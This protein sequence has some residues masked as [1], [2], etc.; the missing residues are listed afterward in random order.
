M[1]AFRRLLSVLLLA[2]MLPSLT[3]AQTDDRAAFAYQRWYAL[4]LE[5]VRHTPTYTPPVASRAFAYVSIAAY[6]AVASGN[7]DLRTLA[8]QLHGLEPLPAR[9]PAAIYDEAIV[10]QAAM[11]DSASFFFSNTGP[12]GQR[13]MT[14]MKADLTERTSAGVDPETGAR[15][16]AFGKAIADHIIAWSMDDGGATI[17]NMG[18]PLDY[19]A[20]TKPFEWVP[21]SAIRQQ[22]MPLLPEWGTNRPFAMPQD[23]CPLPP[24][25]AYSEEVG[26]QFRI[27]AQE[28]HDVPGQLT[29][30]QKLI[31]RFWSDDPMLSP[32]PPGHWVTI[33]LDQLALEDAPLDRQVEVLAKLGITVAD[34]FI[35][36]WK[37]KYEYDLL[38]PVTY[39]RRVLDDKWSPLLITPPFPEYPSG[40]STQSGAAATVLTALFGENHA[41]TDTTHEDDG[42]PARDFPDFWAA[43]NEAGISRLY[44][45][46]HFRS[47]ID[48]GLDQGRCV[49]D[50]TN[51]LVTRS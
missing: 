19:P 48:L 25:P 27:E 22:Q 30:E 26:S 43:A 38:R 17:V 37:M 49:G 2:L 20:A 10:I 8:G 15:S 12:T 36:N 45:G 40:H 24:P 9:D 50:F 51:A 14:A 44:G 18:F 46:I 4:V 1:T 11:A 42:L 34:A 21:T 16:A 28:V 39:I 29:D 31:A 32:T 6:E 47:A 35:A 41:F 23:A 5:L 13:A 33:A 3:M 7:T